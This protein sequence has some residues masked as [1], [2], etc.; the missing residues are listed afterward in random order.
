MGSEDTA[1]E[2]DKLDRILAE[3]AELAAV[4]NGSANK[5]ASIQTELA[6]FRR[7]VETRLTSL[8]LLVQK[9]VH[10]QIKFSRGD[11]ASVD[12]VIQRVLKSTPCRGERTAV[13]DVV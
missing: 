7:S 5:I 13:A 9:K 3:V 8:V 11:Q 6:E 4:V 10:K 12:E 2:Y 1:K